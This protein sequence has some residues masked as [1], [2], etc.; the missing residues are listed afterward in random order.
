MPALV[1]ARVTARIVGLDPVLREATADVLRLALKGHPDAEADVVGDGR[2]VAF[3]RGHHL[4]L[5][6]V[7][8]DAALRP[9]THHV[10]DLVDR[11]CGVFEA[12]G[13][14][15][16]A[17]GIADSRALDR[18]LGAIEEGIEHLG[19]Q[20][21][22]LGLLGSEA[23]IAPDRL[24]RGLAV[25]RQPLVAAPGGHHREAGSSRPVH[26]VADDRRLV[27]VGQAVDDA[28]SGGALGQQRP[29]ERIRLHGHHDDVL[30]V[31]ERIQGMFNGR[32]RVAGGLHDDLDFGMAAQRLPVF[33]DVRVTL[34][35]GCIQRRGPVP[36]GLPAGAPK[37]GLR[38]RGRKV[39]NAD[40]VH[41]RRA[42]HL[43]D[44]H[45]AEF[46]CADHAHPDGLAGGFAL[47]QLAVEV[48][49]RRPA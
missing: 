49:V 5:P 33:P 39:R 10:R 22:D 12:V 21:A 13:R 20:P 14:G 16:E 35:H 31:L 44:V 7:V 19:V 38:V 9:G 34:L 48:H 41:A 11:A 43:G 37:V 28:R 47:L 32:D 45:G 36:R 2:A 26:E 18:G 27:A 4:H 15:R 17:R 8:Q 1:Q 29:A 6:L 24:R 42:R 40:E 30:A 23:V 25:M 46:A 3:E